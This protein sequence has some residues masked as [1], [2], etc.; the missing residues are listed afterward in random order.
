LAIEIGKIPAVGFAGKWCFGTD[1]LAN[2]YWGFPR[3]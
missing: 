3:I 1:F 2:S